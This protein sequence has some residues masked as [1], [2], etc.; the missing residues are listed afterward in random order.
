MKIKLFRAI[1][2]KCA[3]H[4]NPPMFHWKKT[5]SLGIKFWKF[6]RT[7]AG[8]SSMLRRRPAVLDFWLTQ[9]RPSRVSFDMS[10]SNFQPLNTRVKIFKRNSHPSNQ[11]LNTL[12]LKIEIYIYIPYVYIYIYIYDP[13]EKKHPPKDL[14]SPPLPGLFLRRRVGERCC[15][16]LSPEVRPEVKISASKV[17]IFLGGSVI[18]P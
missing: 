6:S 4:F 3:S 14:I 10:P 1:F 8:Q 17:L 13:Q 18:P 16:S 5:R 9:M 2:S 12:T 15:A 7:R 11:Q